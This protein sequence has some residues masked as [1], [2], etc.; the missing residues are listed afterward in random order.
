MLS[1]LKKIHILFG[2]SEDATKLKN[3]IDALR[4]AL[5]VDE[6]K[7]EKQKKKRE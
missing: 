5:E 4:V 3:T 2:E 1:A 7:K 6:K